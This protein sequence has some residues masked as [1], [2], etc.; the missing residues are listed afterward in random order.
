MRE[1]IKEIF[2]KGSFVE[3]Y[4]NDVQPLITGTAMLSGKK[5][6]VIADDPDVAGGAQGMDSISKF[7]RFNRYCERFGIPLVE[8]NDSP[9]FTPGSAQEHAGIQGEGGKSIREECLSRNLKVAVTLNQ[10]YGGRLIH[11]NLKTLGPKR[12]GLVLEGA[13]VGVM[14]AKGA[15]WVLHGKK[16]STI[17]DAAERKK[18]EEYLIKEYEQ[19]KLSPD[20]M[21]NLGYA[22]KVIKSPD[23]RTELIDIF[24]GR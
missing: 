22:E 16:L 8:L 15:V 20:Q 14:G 1:R 4:A 7:T 2:D 12:L 17:K 5:V 9:A 11:A 19:E 23:I 6:G 21:V 13:K 10:N 18:K 24:R 3:F